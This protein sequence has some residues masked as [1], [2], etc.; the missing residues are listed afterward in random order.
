MIN[1]VR[2][3]S[4][5][6]K[7]DFYIF[8]SF[9]FCWLFP[10]FSDALRMMEVR[11]PNYT[12]KDNMVRLEC[13]YDMENEILYSVKWYKDGQEF[14]RYLPKDQP[15]ATVFPLTGISVDVRMNL[16]K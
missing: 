9:F 1:N 3:L 6:Q 4:N 14:Y 16:W 2:S 5:G 8:F 15:P 13:H 12:V 10:E 7:Y 11:V